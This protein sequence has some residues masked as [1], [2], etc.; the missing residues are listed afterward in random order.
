[1][2]IELT[3]SEVNNL[4]AALTLAACRYDEMKGYKGEAERYRTLE[5]KL[6][7]LCYSG[8]KISILQLKTQP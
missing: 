7:S 2:E 6:R 3:K 5:Y 4:I 1:M 8:D